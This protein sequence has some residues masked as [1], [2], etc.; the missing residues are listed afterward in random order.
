MRIEMAWRDRARQLTLRLA[1]GARMRP[2]AKR[3]LEVRVAGEKGTHAAVFEGR[4]LTLR[5]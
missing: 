1:P 3:P 5:L 2:P 4:P